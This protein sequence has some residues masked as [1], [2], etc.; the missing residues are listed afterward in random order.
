[1]KTFVFDSYAWIGFFRKEK[2]YLKIAEFLSLVDEGNFHLLTS[3]INLGEVF[4]MLKR[5]NGVD[6]A[7]YSMEFIQ[8]T[9][10]VIKVP[11]LE[12]I[13]GAAKIK[14]ENKLSYAD[15]F[16]IQLSIHEDGTLISN[17]QEIKVL[18][19]KL[20]FTCFS[21]SDNFLP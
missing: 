19:P 5:K 1:M 10:G 2:G 18:A 11:T 6:L 4:Y 16:A 14:S 8:S 13:L 9:P 20:G 3:A 12:D 15:S 21:M 7:N 17:D